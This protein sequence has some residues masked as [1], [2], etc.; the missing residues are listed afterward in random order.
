MEEAYKIALTQLQARKVS[1][2]NMCKKTQNHAKIT[3]ITHKK[4]KSLLKPRAK[5][6]TLHNC[7][8]LALTASEPF[9]ISADCEQ[10]KIN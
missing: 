10:K 8:K 7:E 3:K 4:G 9:S 2:Q 5:T 6:K 1:T